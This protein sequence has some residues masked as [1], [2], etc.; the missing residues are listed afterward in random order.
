MPLGKKEVH[1]VRKNQESVKRFC[2]WLL[3]NRSSKVQ[4]KD[5]ASRIFVSPGGKWG[6]RKREVRQIHTS[7]RGDLWVQGKKKVNAWGRGRQKNCSAPPLPQD[8][9]NLKNQ[10]VKECG[11]SEK[12]GGITSKRVN[13]GGGEDRSSRQ[14]PETSMMTTVEKKGKPGGGTCLGEREP[15]GTP[16]FSTP[17][18]G[19]KAVKK[20]EQRRNRVPQSDRRKTKK[21]GPVRSWG[22]YMTKPG[23]E[24]A[25]M[26]SWSRADRARAFGNVLSFRETAG[27][28][29]ERTRSGVGIQKKKGEN[30]RKG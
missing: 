24:K 19:R 4:G 16:A 14:S 29:N 5:R 26:D 22:T 9:E 23:K 2:D 13:E 20:K 17:G 12:W 8:K 7:F 27:E 15:Q 25:R 11:Q 28:K 1:K 30:A 21:P 6:D 18:K 10:G 3:V